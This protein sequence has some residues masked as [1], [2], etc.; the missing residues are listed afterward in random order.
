MPQIIR[1]MEYA[2]KWIINVI[3]RN[4]PLT[5]VFLIVI[6]ILLSKV[7]YDEKKHIYILNFYNSTLPTIVF[8]F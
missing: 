8:N 6:L 4:R 7:I 5:A 2:L 3:L 1:S